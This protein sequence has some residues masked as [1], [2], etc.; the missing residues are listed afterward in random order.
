M[1][2]ALLGRKLHPFPRGLLGVLW[3]MHRLGR[4]SPWL[5]SRMFVLAPKEAL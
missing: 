4:P 1:V 2:T 3:Y 5:K